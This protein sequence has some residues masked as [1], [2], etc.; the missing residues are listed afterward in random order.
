MSPA[1]VSG[2][3]DGNRKRPLALLRRRKVGG[4]RLEA[5]ERRPVK[6]SHDEALD[7]DWL[8]L[9]LR[10]VQAISYMYIFLLSFPPTFLCRSGCWALLQ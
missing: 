10:D 5:V 8:E 6:D 3:K 7:I 9:V 4:R 1:H 2:E